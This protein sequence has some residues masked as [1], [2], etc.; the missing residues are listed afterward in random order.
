MNLYVV[1]VKR[2]S[3]VV[4]LITDFGQM[5]ISDFGL[6]RWLPYQCSQIMTEVEGTFG[7]IF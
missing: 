2:I 1:N 5:Q 4:L 7:Y 6:A 3:L